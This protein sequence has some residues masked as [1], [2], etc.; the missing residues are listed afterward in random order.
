MIFKLHI[1]DQTR[2]VQSTQKALKR[3]MYIYLRE[4]LAKG[5]LLSN[6]MYC[7]HPI[8]PTSDIT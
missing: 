1:G 4:R 3:Q 2:Y 7:W 6:I 8:H 5:E